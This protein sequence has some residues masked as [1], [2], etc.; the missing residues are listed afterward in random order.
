MQKYVPGTAV[1]ARDADLRYPEDGP[2]GPRGDDSALLG[3]LLDRVPV[4][5]LED[6]GDLWLYTF[7]GDDTHAREHQARM[8]ELGAP[9][10]FVAARERRIRETLAHCPIPRPAVVAGP[11]GPA[12]AVA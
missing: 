4:V 10:E 5:H 1:L 8:N 11:D 6:A 2:H 9:R 3:A 7:R 12:F